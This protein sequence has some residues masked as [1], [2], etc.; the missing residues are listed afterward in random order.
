MLL[1]MP[2]ARRADRRARGRVR[3][4]DGPPAARTSCS[5]AR[6][7]SGRCS[8]GR[9]AGPS[10]HCS[11]S[12]CARAWRT[13]SRCRASAAD[14][15]SPPCSSARRAAWP[16]RASPAWS[17]SRRSAMGIGAMCTV[18]LGLPLTATLLATLLIG[19]R[20]PR[21]DA[22]GDRRGRRGLRHDGA[23]HASAARP[24]RPL[25]A[26]QRRR[27]TRPPTS[28]PITVTR[29]SWPV[30]ISTTAS[31]WPSGVAAVKSPKPGGR[32][33]GEAEVHAIAVTDIRL[34][35]VRRA[36][37][38]GHERDDPGEEEPDVEVDRQR[39]EDGS[40][41]DPAL[42]DQSRDAAD[43]R[44]GDRRRE[45]AADHRTRRPAG[46]RRRRRGRPR[47]RRPRRPPARG[48]GGSRRG[49]AR[50]R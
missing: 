11:C 50:S 12:W 27:P 38:G 36:V 39:A 21:R 16:P 2:R 3:R 26:R 33:D 43:Q 18:M 47:G 34:R 5:P 28:T 48:H 35:E 4:G 40:Q 1:L 22:A 31:A 49:P 13:R 25:H 37:H 46:A 45:Q 29:Y 44:R 10:A 15:C 42:A 7:S 9:P 8:P 23:P 17:S 14:R 32:Q 24:A 6:T 20:R 30:S 19:H 41:R